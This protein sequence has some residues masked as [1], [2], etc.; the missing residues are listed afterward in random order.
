M[1]RNLRNRGGG[2]S[3]RQ[4]R[5]RLNPMLR[6]FCLNFL[7]FFSVW[8]PDATRAQEPSQPAS[9][10]PALRFLAGSETPTSQ[11]QTDDKGET[12]SIN[13]EPPVKPGQT[14]GV[15]AQ[16]EWTQTTTIP[17]ATDREKRTQVTQMRVEL[18]A[19]VQILE[20]Y[21]NGLPAVE[22]Y[23]V[24]RC[25]K[26]DEKG[27]RSSIASVGTTVLATSRE[28][29]PWY[30]LDGKKAPDA[31]VQALR[32]V[33]PVRNPLEPL[34][35]QVFG[36][37]RPRPLG[38]TWGIR[39]QELSQA[40]RRRGVPV[41]E[42]SV[43]GYTRL[44]QVSDFA[45]AECLELRSEVIYTNFVPPSTEDFKVVQGSRRSS[46]TVKVPQDGRT[47]PLERV[48]DTE[49]RMG[50][51]Q[52]VVA[53]PATRESAKR[54]RPSENPRAETL[55]VETLYR[56]HLRQVFQYEGFEP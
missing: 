18:D 56:H 39:T 43:S 2:D 24:R 4:R 17:R 35:D 21:P 25:E 11:T 23:T 3:E 42:E 1:N 53:A 33:I 7:F 16:G 10:R 48:T 34:A 32:V 54:D 27:K 19:R 31:L 14:Y 55:F 5:K 28:G 9:D 45:D 52:R 44:E 41:S 51:R 46:M 50:G 22:L 8:A 40:W 36:S 47:G 13:L 6:F 30:E 12:Y 37:D 20:V 49:T 15:S 38:S 26:F 29:Q